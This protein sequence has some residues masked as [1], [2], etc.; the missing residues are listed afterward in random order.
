MLLF[1]ETITYYHQYQRELKTDTDTGEQY[2]EST[3]EDI[4]AAFPCWKT[5]C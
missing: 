3:T 2:I 5:P 4:E 1:I